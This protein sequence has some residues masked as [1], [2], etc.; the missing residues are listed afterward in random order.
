[1]RLSPL[2]SGMYRNGWTHAFQSGFRSLLIDD[3]LGT[4]L[5]NSLSE[6]TER[7]VGHWQQLV[8]LLAQNP[9]HFRAEE[10]ASGLLRVRQ[11]RDRVPVVDRVKAVEMLAGRLK[12]TPLVQLLS[13]DEP[14]V[15][16]AVIRS[17]NL[18]DDQWSSIIPDLPVRARGF[19][20]NRKDL[21]P[22][23]L[24][25]LAYWGSGDFTLPQPDMAPQLSAQPS[26]PTE[27]EP[28]IAPS[29]SGQ[30]IGAVVARI[31]S[32]RKARENN[33]APQLPFDPDADDDQ[34]EAIEEIRFETNDA[35]TIVWVEGAPR[36]AIVGISID[37]AAFDNG[38]GPDAFG[39][40]A[41]RQRMAMN[42]ARMRLRGASIVEG[43]WRMTAAPFFDPDS[44]R[45]RGFRGIMRRPNVAETALASQQVSLQWEQMQQVV[46]ELRTPL[47]AI[48]GFA[49]IIEQQLF[50]PVSREYR[51]L[52]QA[53]IADAQLLLAGFDDISAA[54]KSERNGSSDRIQRTECSWLASRVAERLRPVS[55][56]IGAHIQLRMADPVRAFAIDQ[57]FAERLFSRLLSAVIMGCSAGEDLH[58]R[59]S[60]ELGSPVVNCFELTLPRQ[61]R[62]LSE[63]ELLGS[64][65]ASATTPLLGLGFSLRLVRNLAN[66]AGGS[67]QFQKDRLLI[68]LPAAENHRFLYQDR[69]SE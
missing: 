39:A 23:T 25:A 35:G 52:A 5:Q 27:S 26:V 7:L 28:D 64:A 47:G 54:A 11:L 6:G 30:S 16:A 24:R 55:D 29:D 13:G 34:L 36:G 37:E 67:L 33:L 32:W 58:G 44:G 4:A 2:A 61:L 51:E 15:A 60:T 56:G 22:L 63:D 68:R 46:H 38:P 41:F 12:S 31:E 66:S 49:E 65:T 42:G 17:A 69:R 3:R 10:V 9:A 45:F 53:I 1:M 20:R 40:A 21:G 62:D 59:F 48:A 8:D 19:L 43:E 18:S 50:G 57:E 14:A